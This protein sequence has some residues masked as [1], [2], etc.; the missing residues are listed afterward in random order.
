MQAFSKELD[1]E[2]FCFLQFLKTVKSGAKV[3]NYFFPEFPPPL[4]YSWAPVH[5][6]TL[7]NF[8]MIRLHRLKLSKNST[9]SKS[10][11]KRQSFM[12]RRLS[13]KRILRSS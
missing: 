10:Q 12:N 5:Y 6:K 3:T 9:V 11:Q 4:P 13:F 7:E 2:S 1:W 8:L